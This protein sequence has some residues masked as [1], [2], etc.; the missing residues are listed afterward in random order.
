VLDVKVWPKLTD[1]PVAGKLAQTM[2]ALVR[3]R[4]DIRLT[5]MN[6]PLASPSATPTRCGSR[7][8]VLAGGGPSDVVAS[9]SH[10]RE[11]LRHAGPARRR[12]RIGLADGRASGQLEPHESAQ[13]WGPIRSTASG[14][15]PTRVTAPL[16]TVKSQQQALPFRESVWR[17]G[18][19]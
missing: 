9:P 11:M 5:N 16:A 6:A 7:Q 12:R 14:E 3:C 1:T 4:V 18:V 19:K 10:L 13:W 8:S 17:L 2:V 15:K